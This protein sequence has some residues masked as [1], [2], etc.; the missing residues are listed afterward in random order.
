MEKYYPTWTLQ[1]S[2]PFLQTAK[3]SYAAVLGK[4]PFLDKWTFSTNGV[5]IC[6]I[7]GIPCIGMGP[8][9][10]VYAHA[11]NEAT[12][13]EHLTKAAAFYAAFVA[14]LNGK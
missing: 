2:S 5:T 8:G 13:I 9:N 4:E 3:E 11:A 6:G 7:H 12:E 10:E 1:E 14:K